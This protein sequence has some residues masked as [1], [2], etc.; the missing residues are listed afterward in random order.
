ML[1]LRKVDHRNHVEEL[2]R[3]QAVI[4]PIEDGKA[5]TSETIEVPFYPARNY[6]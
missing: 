3:S 4:P 5:L 1:L 6:V 2:K